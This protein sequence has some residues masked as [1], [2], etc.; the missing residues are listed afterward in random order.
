MSSGTTTSARATASP[1]PLVNQLAADHLQ[2]QCACGDHAVA[3]GECHA[4]ARK[5]GFLQRPTSRLPGTGVPPIVQEVL[6]SQGE[7]LDAATRQFVEPRFGYDLSRVRVHSDSR[8]ADSAAA[9]GASA[10]AFGENLV[11]G[12]GRYAPTTLS[13]RSLLTHELVHVVQQRRGAS[14]ESA[15]PVAM[16]RRGDGPEQ[17]AETLAPRIVRGE[18]V[19]VQ[20]R[21]AGVVQRAPEDIAKGIGIGAGIVGGGVGLGLLVAWAAGA[22]DKPEPAAGDPTI[23]DNPPSCGEKQ[24]TKIRPVLKQAGEWVSKAIARFRA[25]KGNPKAPSQQAVQERV[26]ARFAKGASNRPE[27]LDKI[28]RVVGLIGSRLAGQNFK[29]ECHNAVTDNLCAKLAEAYVPGYGSTVVLCPSFFADPNASLAL[30]HELAHSLMAGPGRI[31]DRGYRSERILPMLSTEEALTN[32]ES[33][34]EF[35]VDLAASTVASTA[36]RDVIGKSCPDDWKQ[37]IS[38]A[39]AKAQRWNMN[40]FNSVTGSDRSKMKQAEI[41][42]MTV[43]QKTSDRLKAPVQ[44]E[45][46][47]A[48]GAECAGAVYWR[49]PNSTLFL[50]S[51]WKAKSADDQAVS[52]LNAF[53]GTFA[54]VATEALRAGYAQRAYQI[55]QTEF[56]APSKLAVFGNPAWTSAAI[57]IHFNV[58][59][60]IHRSYEESGAKHTRLSSEVPVYQGPDCLSSQLPFECSTTFFVD[61]GGNERPAPFKPPR[62]ATK[63]AFKSTGAGAR[64][65]R[66]QEDPNPVY[67]GAGFNLKTPLGDPVKLTFADNGI[68]GIRITLD[69]PDSGVSRQYEDSLQVEAVRPCNAPAAPG[70]TGLA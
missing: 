3:G 43:Y 7:P 38:D 26:D 15:P 25:Y 30:I 29:V 61:S 48:G 55:T 64:I 42:A 62:L 32:A 31:A 68:L 17:E 67:Q 21:A 11:F 46:Q 51:S 14:V 65:D 57:A 1:A 23:V 13:G 10:Y 56:A 52:M 34:A 45:C 70:V 36:P 24:N 27:V 4:C 44:F 9:I 47:P 20:E 37:P 16:S 19:D 5:R 22:F 63:F 59:Q 60:P 18:S 41:D 49:Q 40:A 39:I 54:G 2:R 8:A 33:Y 58:S 53:Y 6:R 66:S 50:C 28:D 69:D 12:A 35:I